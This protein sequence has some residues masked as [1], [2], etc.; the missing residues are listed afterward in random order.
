M[1]QLWLFLIF[2]IIVSQNLIIDN[3][4]YAQTK[5][6]STSGDCSPYIDKVGGS[7]TVKCGNNDIE[8]EFLL[9]ILGSECR[10]FSKRMNRWG[11]DIKEW[12]WIRIAYFP[13]FN[14]SIISDLREEKATVYAYDKKDFID[15]YRDAIAIPDAYD[16]AYNYRSTSRSNK[17]QL[18]V[19]DRDYL[20]KV[21]S[22]CYW[23]GVDIQ[24]AN[25]VA[26]YIPDNQFIFRS[27]QESKKLFKKF[28]DLKLLTQD[29]KVSLSGY[30][31]STSDNI[32][33]AFHNFKKDFVNF[34]VGRVKENRFVSIEQTDRQIRGSNN[35]HGIVS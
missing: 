21:D 18:G 30:W 4:S 24:F 12:E 14:K 26:T 33:I 5:N 23:A 8:V 25:W 35:A 17:Y 11:R 10:D 31:C 34:E 29:E 13:V 6:T 28:S 19:R 16:T 32:F 2:I 1:R 7:V 22:L 20:R 9:A 15:I 27:D 3:V